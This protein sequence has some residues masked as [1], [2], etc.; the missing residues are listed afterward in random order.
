MNIYVCILTLNRLDSLRR[1]IEG[2]AFL[3]GLLKPCGIWPEIVVMDQGSTDGTADY[4]RYSSDWVDQVMLNDRNL[5][6]AGGRRAIVDRLIDGGLRPIDTVVFLDDDLIADS[7][8]WLMGLMHGFTHGARTPVGIVGVDGR[9]VTPDWMTAP[10]VEGLHRRYVGYADYVSGGWSAV[11]GE[12]LLS[13]VNFDTQFNPNYWEDVDLCYQARAAGWS[14]YA[15][16]DIGLRHEHFAA[17]VS[18]LLTVNGA[19][20]RAKWE[21]V[22]DAV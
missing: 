9:Q 1:L 14:V 10:M 8:E 7:A 2:A 6:C 4:L 15:V 3:D 11:A 20:F 13:G 5:G 21:K 16:G 18:V 12:T 19:K 22:R 17:G